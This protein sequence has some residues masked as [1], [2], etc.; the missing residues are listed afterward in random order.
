MLERGLDVFLQPELW[1]FMLALALALAGIVIG[2]AL[3]IRTFLY[4]GVAF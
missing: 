1:V 3:R 2:I 4:A